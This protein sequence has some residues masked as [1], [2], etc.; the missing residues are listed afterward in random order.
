L[1]DSIN[2]FLVYNCEFD[3]WNKSIM[4]DHKESQQKNSFHSSFI[5]LHS[6]IINSQFVLKNKSTSCFVF[7][8]AI[9]YLINS[10]EDMRIYFFQL[11]IINL[12]SQILIDSSI[13]SLSRY[14]CFLYKFFFV[15]LSCF[16]SG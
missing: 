9:V 15:S 5:T 7:T 4:L 10:V 3:S 11:I 13:I 16:Y 6:Q 12:T 2:Y 14:F 8:E 1:R